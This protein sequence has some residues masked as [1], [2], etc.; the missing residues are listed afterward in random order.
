MADA[1]TLD[2]AAEAQ[3]LKHVAEATVKALELLAGATPHE[4]IWRKG[5]VRLRAYAPEGKTT[6]APLLLVTPIINR[7]RIVDLAP[8]GLSLVQGLTQA[9][10]PVYVV[11][12]GDPAVID[13]G[14]DFSDYVLR[15]LPAIQRVVEARHQ[16]Q[17]L[18]VI[19]YCLGGTISVMYAA[20][21]PER[22]KRLITLNTPVDF[23]T[24]Q[25]FMDLLREWVDPRWFPVDRI[26]EAFGNMPGRL[27]A[28]G[29][30][31]P[32]PVGSALK[33]VRAWPRFESAEF[34]DFFSVLESWNQDSVDV[35]GAAYRTLITQL[36]RQNDLIEG[37]I[38]PP[39][40]PR[41]PGRDPLPGARGDLLGGHDL[42]ARSRPRAAR[43][44]LDPQGSA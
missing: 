7:Y 43:E 5:P 32:T 8:E 22:V 33:F 12:W 20:R 19:G 17:S 16:V 11:D 39:R 18:D 23:A 10:I 28:Q 40:P 44:G 34:A 41:A 24:G 29:F 38:T 42:P 27:I 15:Y 36:Y 6:R 3:R 31:W 2:P 4:V 1:A 9:G 13:R 25:P 37:R 26:T 14:T 21:F 35:P 30:V